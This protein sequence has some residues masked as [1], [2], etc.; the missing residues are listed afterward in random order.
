MN[1][2]NGLAKYAVAVAATAAAGGAATSRSVGGWYRRLR[3]PPFQPPPQA[4]G[5]VW[6]GLYATMAW[7][8]WRI[9]KAPP[10]AARTR[11]LRLWW[12]QLALNAAWSP[13]FFGARRPKAALADLLLLT[14]AV[15]AYANAARR[16]DAGA[17]AMMLPYL[18]WLGFAGVLNEEIVRRNR[19][20]I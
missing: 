8:A 18:A 1:K 6:T 19:R 3:K 13:L 14:G 16:V 17:A 20:R 11:A 5:P 2:L 10:S 15:V 7:S 9:W 12:T 4:F